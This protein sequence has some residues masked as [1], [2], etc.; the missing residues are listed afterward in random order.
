MKDQWTVYRNGGRS[1]TILRVGH[2]VLIFTAGWRSPC[3]NETWWWNDTVQKVT[4][5]KKEAMKMW[6]T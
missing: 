1:T 4:K 5:D 6:E 3:D 2:D